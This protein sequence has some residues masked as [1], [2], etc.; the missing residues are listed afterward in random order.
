ML[1][2]QKRNID[3]FIIFMGL[4][5][6]IFAYFQI[7]PRYGVNFLDSPTSSEGIYGADFNGIY[8]FDN[9]TI[10]SDPWV[11]ANGYGTSAEI[12]HSYSGHSYVYELDSA[13]RRADVTNDMSSDWKVESYVNLDHLAYTG[14][15]GGVYAIILRA[16]NTQWIF[17]GYSQIDGTWIR[18]FSGSSNQNIQSAENWS[19]NSWMYWRV[20]FTSATDTFRF[21]INNTLLDTIMYSG[22]NVLS[23]IDFTS[24]SWG[25]AGL[26]RIDSLCYSWHQDYYTNMLFDLQDSDDDGMPNVWELVNGLDPDD[27]SD[28]LEDLDSDGLL[29]L[30]EYTHSTDPNDPDSDNDGLNDGPEVNTYLTNPN[31]PDSDNDGLNDGPEVNTYLTNPNDEDSDN[32]L[33]NDGAEVNTYLT[34]PNDADSDDDGLNDG[35][36]INTYSTDPNNADSDGD[37]FSDKVEIDAGTDP[38]DPST[39]PGTIL[40]TK[41]STFLILMLFAVAVSITGVRI[42]KG[43]H[44]RRFI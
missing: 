31:D 32:D 38:N 14:T 28:A 24:G 19:S 22:L 2:K 3:V 5:V 7:T 27:N 4:I 18:N 34:N 16:F 13:Y 35:V 29:N 11:A 12:I 21:Y 43:Q 6:L 15:G 9:Y 36:E 33:L 25:D 26:I 42:S 20:E 37:T 17:W 30:Y 40:A 1:N 8:T 10:G 39:N 44:K 41:F 23:S